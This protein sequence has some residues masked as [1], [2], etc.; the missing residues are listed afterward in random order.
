MKKYA[1]FSD[2]TC[3]LTREERIKYG[4]MPEVFTQNMDCNGKP[5]P[6]IDANEFYEH[7]DNGEYPAGTLKTSSA[8]LK[9]A[10]RVLDSAL[11][12]ADKD[13]VI[14]YVGVS[15]LMSSGTVNTMLLALNDYIEEHKDRD[16]MYIDSE[17]ISNGQATFLQYLAKY[18][19]DDIE[20]YAYNLRKHIVHLFTE[21][22]FS[23]SAESGR[24]N[25][26]ERFTMKT[27]TKLHVSPWMHFPSDSK[28]SVSRLIRSGGKGKDK[29]V[30][31]WVDYYI[32]NVAD[33]NEF[34][35]I[36]YGGTAELERAQLL[37][38]QLKERA[39]LT[40]D[41]IQLARVSPIVGAHTGSTVLSFF[42]K[43]KNER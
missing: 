38:D 20:H 39:G 35:R 23:Y 32:K 2:L 33:D 1:I 14:V 16:F 11:E 25:G 18:D 43:Q 29:L 9:E 4:I 36:G 8:G 27:F 21:R 26:I 34:V 31:A 28:L 3:D 37:I 24:Y 40:D 19:G 6:H 17:C 13:A 12:H 22:D 30:S 41:Q 42:F 10:Y 5:V 15:P 7:F